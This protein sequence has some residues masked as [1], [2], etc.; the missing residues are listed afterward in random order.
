VNFSDIHGQDSYGKWNAKPG[1]VQGLDL[2]YSFNKSFGLQTGINVSTVYYEHRTL[3]DP[4]IYLIDLFSYKPSYSSFAPYYYY[5]YNEKMDFTFIRIPLL[6]T[7]SIPDAL[8]FNMRAGIYFSSL[9]DH[10]LPYDYYSSMSAE[11]PKKTDFGYIFSSGIAYPFN[12]HFKATFSVGYIDGRKKFLEN[13]EYRHGSSE[14][15]LGVAYKGFLKRRNSQVIEE[16]VNDTTAGKIEVT[17]KAGINISWNTSGTDL[18]KYSSLVG[19]SFGF[20]LNYKLKNLTSIQTGLSFERKGYSF[21]D[22]SLFFYRYFHSAS[23]MY[24]VNTKVQIDYIVIPVLM[25]F[26]F[27]KSES[28]YFNTGPWLGLKLNARCVGTAISESRS[29]TNYSLNKTIVYD[30]MEKLIKNNDFGWIFGGGATLPLNTKFKL[31]LALQYSAGFIDVFDRSGITDNIYKSYG[32]NIITNG[33]LS[34]LIGIKFRPSH[35]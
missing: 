10:S 35:H 21:K 8:N 15:T 27:N 26:Y 20:T 18:G 17:Y 16:P 13:Y 31:D 25:N 24:D 3:S 14:F 11:K 12:D 34:F 19:S 6:F 32:K 30:D 22:S 28:V 7:V 4:P 23:N 2:G 9:Q 5:S 29:G 33:T 1:P